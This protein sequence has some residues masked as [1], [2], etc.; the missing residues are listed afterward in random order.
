MFTFFHADQAHQGC[1]ETGRYRHGG[2]IAVKLIADGEDYAMLSVNFPSVD[3][4]ADEFLF[5]TYSENDGLLEA[6]L[7]AGVIAVIGTEDTAA[8][9][10]PVCRLL[11]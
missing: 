1:I 10:M 3:L 4:A 5:K 2:G 9:P 8:G 11:P 7:A 6:M